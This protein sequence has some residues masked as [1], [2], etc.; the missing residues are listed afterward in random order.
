MNTRVL[1]SFCSCLG[2]TLLRRILPDE[3]S[4][5]SPILRGQ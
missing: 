1:L 4:A 5:S 3:L 2:W